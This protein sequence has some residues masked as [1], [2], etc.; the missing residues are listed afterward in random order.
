MKGIADDLVAEIKKALKTHSPSQV[1]YAIGRFV[2]AGLHLGM[3]SKTSELVGDRKV[4]LGVE[5]F[6]GSATAYR[7]WQPQ[8]IQLVSRIMLAVPPIACG[9]VL[10]HSEHAIIT[11]SSREAFWPLF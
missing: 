3:S 8:W 6:A 9:N 5:G 7:I 1:M 4:L 11:K 2:G 10:K